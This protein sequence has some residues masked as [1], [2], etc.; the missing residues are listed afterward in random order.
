M[1]V[2]TAHPDDETLGF[3]FGTISCTKRPAAGWRGASLPKW[4]AG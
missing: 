3:G 1:L 2:I 4:S